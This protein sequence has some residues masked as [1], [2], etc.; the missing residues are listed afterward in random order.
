MMVKKFDG[1][2]IT[3]VQT[4]ALGTLADQA[5]I[6]LTSLTLAEDFRILRSEIF[7]GAINFD[8]NEELQGLLFGIVNGALTAPLIANAVV[9]GGPLNRNDRL[10]IELAERWVKVLSQATPVTQG[11][12]SD[13][14]NQSCM[15]RGE[16]NSPLITSKDRWTYQASEG[17]SF[18]VFNN[19]GSALT[20]GATARVT[21]KHFGV[22]V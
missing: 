17:W 21:A 8:D 3:E 7:A 12:L 19:T 10:N 9:A 16:G 11:N 18:F 2:I 20:T 14:T 6:E 15:F 4:V 22:W 5:A 1:V 13:R